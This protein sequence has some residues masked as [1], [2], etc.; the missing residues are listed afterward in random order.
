A[1]PGGPGCRFYRPPAYGDSHFYSASPAECAQVAAQYPAFVYETA[2]TFYI[3]L[4]DAA[5]GAC[6]AGWSPV[7]RVCDTPADTN[8]RSTT[9][10]TVRKQMVGQGWIGEAYGPSQVI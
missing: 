9:S 2:A 1:R 10:A 5:T 7:Y 8:H 6:A 4:P 3:G